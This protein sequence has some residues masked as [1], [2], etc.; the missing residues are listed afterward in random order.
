MLCTHE[1]SC[2][3][4]FHCIIPEYLLDD[5]S[6]SLDKKVRES[7]IRSIAMSKA[8]IATRTEMAQLARLESR[9]RLA[10]GKQ[11][12][13]FSADNQDRL[14]GRLVRSEGSGPSSDQA[15]DEVYDYFGNTYDF[16]MNVFGR[17]SV[18]GMGLPLV[19]T[20][21]IGRDYSNAFWNGREMGF[22][23][24]DGI[25]FNRFTS[26]LDVIGHELT[27]GVVQ[28]NGG[29]GLEY[30]D[31]SGALNESCSDVFGVLV[32]QY[33]LGQT[34]N[35]ADWLLGSEI[36]VTAPC[37]RSMRDPHEGLGRSPNGTQGQPRHMNEYDNTSLDN[38]GVHI[39]SG[40]PNYAFYKFAMR[41]GGNAWDRPGRIWYDTLNGGN[42]PPTATTFQIFA[43]E[44]MKHA[45]TN[46]R[47][48]L[49]ASWAEVGITVDGGSAGSNSM[50][51]ELES[52]RDE[53]NVV[54]EGMT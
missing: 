54:I 31:Q 34:V 24:G 3:N 26:S 49:A 27:H 29:G 1:G 14:R 45:Q 6:R 19:G 37:L 11:R 41:R 33:V 50:K 46:E 23:D 36:M 42:L 38:R 4:P 25:L 40:I 5:M 47:T 20:V 51:Q 8:F 52:I 7:A 53:L 16:Y 32:K 28:F 13:V 15:A 44:T 18:D 12:S 22:G 10:L 17:D 39:N 30:F 9:D 43:N 21:H 35:D 48:D 2:R